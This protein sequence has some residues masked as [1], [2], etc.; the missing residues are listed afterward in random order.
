MYS[1]PKVARDIGL[2]SDHRCVSPTFEFKKSSRDNHRE[3]RNFKGWYP[4]LNTEDKPEEFHRQMN[5][6]LR[7][8]PDQTLQS[9][10]NCIYQAASLTGRTDDGP[11]GLKRPEKNK[12][13]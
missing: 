5:E 1:N 8:D 10:S 13:T 11:A 2:G 12:D 6:S 4:I 7:L 9:I 3:K